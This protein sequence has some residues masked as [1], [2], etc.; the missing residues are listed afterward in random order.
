MA[1]VAVKDKSLEELLD[2]S[3][4]LLRR[5]HRKEWEREIARTDALLAENRGATKKFLANASRVHK[6]NEEMKRRLAEQ[7]PRPLTA[8]ERDLVAAEERRLL[9]EI[10]EGM[11]SKVEQRRNPPGTGDRQRAWHDRNKTKI[12][13]WRKARLLLQPDSDERDLCNLERYRPEGPLD[14][15]MADS[16]MPRLVGLSPRAKANYDDI[17]WSSPEV[18]AAIERLIASGAIKV[19]YQAKASAIREPGV[20]IVEH[21]ATGD[22]EHITVVPRRARG[23]GRRAPRAKRSA[24]PA[25]LAAIARANAARI[26]KRNA[27]TAEA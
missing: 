5:H 10:R 3:T 14:L 15:P 19:N 2:P 27:E 26:A 13:R 8:A 9:A 7:S 25:Q 4:P 6:Q 16:E 17:D 11:V 24:T 20:E 18:R 1:A 23:R 21:Q 22:V 12:L